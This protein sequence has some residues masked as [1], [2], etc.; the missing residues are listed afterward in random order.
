[1]IETI[2]DFQIEEARRVLDNHVVKPLTKEGAFESGLWCICSQA[3]PWEIATKFVYNLRDMSFN[4]K[5]RA[6]RRFA[7]FDVMRDKRKV[8][9]ASVKAGWRFAKG[10][11]FE[12][13][14]GFGCLCYER[15]ERAWNRNE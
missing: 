13:S 5:Q 10:G 15:I 11:R 1:M 14:I 3:T 4:G 6:E 9:L 12:E 2:N 7:S 8:C